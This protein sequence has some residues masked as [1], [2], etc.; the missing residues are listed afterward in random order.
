MLVFAE[1]VLKV[2][3][4]RLLCGAQRIN[5]VATFLHI[6]VSI[7]SHWRQDTRE[8]SQF[9]KAMNLKSRF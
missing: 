9:G 2:L 1:K 8:L 3:I 5:Q 4:Y 6:Y 7:Y